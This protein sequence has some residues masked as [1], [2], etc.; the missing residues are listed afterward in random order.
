[1]RSTARTSRAYT[2]VEVLIVV[3]ITG[4]AAAV[5]VPQMLSAGTLGVQAAS[6]IVIADLL[7]AQNE[8]IAQ[9]TT[10]RVQF[11]P[12]ENR[13]ILQQFDPDAGASGEWV[14]MSVA[15]KD[16]GSENYIVD[17]D[18]DTRFSEVTLFS[19][20]FGTGNS[21]IEFDPLGSPDNGGTIVVRLRD[22]EYT[23]TVAEFTGRVT[24][25]ET[26]P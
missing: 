10:L 8:A 12:T 20:S 2:L 9:Q 4:L 6:R 22:K 5:V 1:M 13:Y 17:F 23:I 25:A 16:G 19:G 15:W 18:E 11:E 14:P 21:Y 3:V 7:Y 26:T 24:V